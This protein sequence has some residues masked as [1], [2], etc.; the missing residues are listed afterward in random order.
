M[1]VEEASLFFVLMILIMTDI[2]L[3]IKDLTAAIINSTDVYVVEVEVKGTMG[4]QIIWVYLDTEQGG[5]SIDK[6]AKVSNE[7]SLVLDANELITNKYVLN[8]SSP[9]LDRPLID[10]RQYKNSVGRKIKVRYLSE[11][12]GKNIIGKLVAFDGTILSLELEKGESFT[13][14]IEKALETKVLPVW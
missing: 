6:C 3:K 13:I 14:T 4:N 2:E 8:V 5:I 1:R 12:G 7:L 11:E 9:G 10:L